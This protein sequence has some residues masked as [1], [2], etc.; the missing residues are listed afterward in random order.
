MPGPVC[1]GSIVSAVHSEYRKLN[2]ES[3]TLANAGAFGENRA[4]M[5]FDKIANDGQTQ[6]QPAMISRCGGIGLGESLEELRQ[7]LWERFPRP[8]RPR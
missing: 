8:Y 3:G 2:N 4:A 5:H 7:K 6:P 1:C